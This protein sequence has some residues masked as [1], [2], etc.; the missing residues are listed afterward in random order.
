MVVGRVKGLSSVITNKIYSFLYYFL[1]GILVIVAGTVVV[2]ALNIPG[3]WRIF[4]VSS[5]SMSPS[6]SSGSLIVTKPQKEYSIG[7]II[8]FQLDKYQEKTITHRIFNVFENSDSI[9]FATKGDANDA[10]DNNLI[11]INNIV[12]KMVFQIPFGGSVV[13][14]AKTS[15]GKIFLIFIPTIFIVFIETKKIIKELKMMV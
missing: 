15:V 14:A 9:R 8:T 1:I 2:S 4:T 6:I 13:M 10:V 12:G 11:T 7:D 3:G 5:G